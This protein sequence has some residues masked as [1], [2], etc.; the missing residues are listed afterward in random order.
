MKE[1]G[2]KDYGREMKGMKAKEES[3][4]LR[5]KIKVAESAD[6]GKEKTM[7]VEMKCEGRKERIT[8]VNYK[9]KDKGGK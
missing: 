8:E 1:R 3:K 6:G 9:E 7:R 2:T 4:R 5:W